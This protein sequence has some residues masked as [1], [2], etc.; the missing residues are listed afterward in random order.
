MR[1]LAA[2]IELYV[3]WINEQSIVVVHSLQ[4]PHDALGW[5]DDSKFHVLR[6]GCVSVFRP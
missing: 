6:T 1:A 4:Q 2:A 3:D 5:F